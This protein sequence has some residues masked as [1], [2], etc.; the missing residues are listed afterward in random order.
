M[1]DFLKKDQSKAGNDQEQTTEL[2]QAELTSNTIVFLYDDLDRVLWYD[3]A[4]HINTLI[5]RLPDVFQWKYYLYPAAATR[6]ES[7]HEEF[8]S[9]L[10]KAFL[11]IPCTS[12]TFL[13]RFLQAIKIDTRLTPL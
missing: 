2:V 10:G 8:V 3:L 6:G 13:A 4:V 1:F 7:K 12:A 5:L 11:F 9:D